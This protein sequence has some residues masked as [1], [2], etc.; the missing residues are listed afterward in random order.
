VSTSSFTTASPWVNPAR[1]RY[2]QDMLLVL[3]AWSVV[4][5]TGSEKV[6]HRLRDLMG[7]REGGELLEV[8]PLTVDARH[9]VIE[10]IFGGTDPSRLTD[11]QFAAWIYELALVRNRETSATAGKR[12][13]LYRF[14]DESG[15]LLYVGVSYDPD[16]RQRQHMATQ[17]WAPLVAKR[18]DE[19]FETREDALHQEAAAILDEGPIFNEAGRKPLPSLP[20]EPASA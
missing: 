5:V 17:R 3:R 1:I 11:I 15:R 20:P 2:D 6:A 19:W 13:C 18:E 9:A 12:T 14:Y 10:T 8:L 4:A 16:Q 7:L